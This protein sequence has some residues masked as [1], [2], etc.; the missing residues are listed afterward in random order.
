MSIENFYKMC[1]YG[2]LEEVKQFYNNNPEI[3]HG[4]IMENAFMNACC[5]GELLVANWILQMKPQLDI[6]FDNDILFEKVCSWHQ[7][8]SAKFILALTERNNSC[9][10]Y[11]YYKIAYLDDIFHLLKEIKSYIPE[12][13]QSYD[14]L[15]EKEKNNIIEIYRR[16]NKQLC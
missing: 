5:S 14:V 8:K 2:Q 1:L 16:N 6:H 7:Y 9:H 4:N 11:K 3:I 10:Y 13:D 15:M 12:F